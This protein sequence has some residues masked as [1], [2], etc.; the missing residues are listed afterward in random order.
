VPTIA[1]QLVT[2]SQ[3]SRTNVPDYT[4]RS[5]SHPET[6]RVPSWPMRRPFRI[7]V[8]LYLRQKLTHLHSRYILS[9]TG[10]NTMSELHRAGQFRAGNTK[11]APLL[12]ARMLLST[13]FNYS[14]STS[15]H[16]SGRT[17]QH[18]D[19]R[20]ICRVG[21][22]VDSRLRPFQEGS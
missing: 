17:H 19:H 1:V 10:T 9:D 12:T 8:P 4:S 16:L 3:T 5:D 21:R 20:L 18:Q 7:K 22:H 2:T 14:G 6:I 13:A 11:A 15:I